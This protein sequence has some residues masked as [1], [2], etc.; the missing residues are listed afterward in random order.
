MD[1]PRMS[2]VII[3]FET[4]WINWRVFG[5]CAT[6]WSKFKLTNSNICSNNFHLTC[7]FNG[8]AKYVS[9][10][11]IFKMKDSIYVFVVDAQLRGQNQK[12]TDSNISS[13]NLHLSRSFSGWAKDVSSDYL[14][15]NYMNKLTYFWRMLPELIKIQTN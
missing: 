6:N 2:Q 8:W 15:S 12:L 11:Y 7:N 1:E 14:F 9:S 5:G 4:A 3:Y 13:E 10:N